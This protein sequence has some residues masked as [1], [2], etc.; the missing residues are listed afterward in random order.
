M[1]LT[2]KNLAHYLI[3]RDFLDMEDIMNGN[4]MLSQAQSR[5]AIFKV[6]LGCKTGRFVKQLISMDHQNAYFMQ[7]D[8][9]MHYLIHHSE[10]YKALRSGIPPY[11]GYDSK[12]HVFVTGY[13]PGAQ[14][15]FEW[16]EA[17][18]KLSITHAQA[19]ADLLSTLHLNIKNEIPKNPS[20]QF[21]NG[22][23]PWIID[24]PKWTSA[25]DDAFFQW[26]REDAYLT[27]QLDALRLGWS[28]DSLIHGDIK[29]VN[30]LVVEAGEAA[31][32]KLIDW[33]IANLGDPL[34]DVAGL[35]QSYLF[36]WI[37]SRQ[38]GPDGYQLPVLKAHWDAPSRHKVTTAFWEAYAGQQQWS[39]EELKA[40]K[41]KTV[42]Y[43]AARLLQSA[44]ELNQFNPAQF[45]PHSL[46]LIQLVRRLFKAPAKAAKDL[47]GIKDKS[48]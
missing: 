32:I 43:T 21:F 19:I 4:Y 37:V 5:N 16:C 35:L 27:Q 18:Q 10:L 13:Y 14:N 20:L 36:F 12:E 41:E 44:K 2:Q 33:E 40:A 26:L 11:F 46:Q 39:D 9:T 47:L 34:W 3:D 17:H 1:R 6:S 29:L 8:A 42:R 31:Q 25:P 30:F 28:G 7:K 22:E 15:L 48:K 38:P 23:L 24:V 45:S